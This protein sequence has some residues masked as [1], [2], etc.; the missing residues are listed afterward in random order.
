M[1]ADQHV[2]ASPV[3]AGVMDPAYEATA[4]LPADEVAR[5]IREG[6]AMSI[7]EAISSAIYGSVGMGRRTPP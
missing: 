5:C 4:R 6:S 3:F 7:D 1:A 2:R